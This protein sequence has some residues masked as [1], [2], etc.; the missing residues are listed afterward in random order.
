VNKRT[1]IL[2]A[3][4]ATSALS[5]CG[6]GSTSTVPAANPPPAAVKGI[7]TPKSVSVVTA[8]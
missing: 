1:Y 3:L 4:L 5:G 2:L 7:D 8:N 6:G